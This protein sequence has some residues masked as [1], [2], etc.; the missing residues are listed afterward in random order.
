[1]IFRFN[2]VKYSGTRKQILKELESAF[3]PL[4][5]TYDGGGWRLGGEILIS[6]C[7]PYEA[8][9]L[10]KNEILNSVPQEFTAWV[11]GDCVFI[12]DSYGK[13]IKKVNIYEI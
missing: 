7:G 13:L 8:R 5:V 9:K 10:L 6:N 11:D 2:G 4:P 1:M 3:K 12:R